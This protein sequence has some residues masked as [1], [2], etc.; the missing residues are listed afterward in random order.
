MD[1]DQTTTT[2]VHISGRGALSNP[3][4]R[5]NPARTSKVDDG[6]WQDEVATRLDTQVLNESVRTIISTNT[7][8]D[9]P[10]DQSI[11]PYRGCEHG[12]I[13]CY[14]RPTHAY[15]DMS[16][17]LDFETKIVAKRGAADL[18]RRAF[19]RPGYVVRPI[20]IGAN[21]DPYQPLEANLRITRDILEVLREYQH[22]F[23]LITKGAL[24]VR[25]LD[26]LADMAQQQL[27]S[28]AVSV[29]TLDRELKVKLEPRTASPTARLRA[30]EALS[31]AGVRVTMMIAPVIPAINDHELEDILAAGKQAGASA[32][33]FILLRLP[34]EVAPMFREWLAEH[35]P[36]RA[37]HVMS[38]VQQSRGGKDYASGFGTRMRGEGVF[39]KLIERRFMI[40]ARGLGL[41]PNER[42][43][44][45]T[46]LFIRHNDQLTLF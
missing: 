7:S 10:F 44:L 33:N 6:W 42:T 4:N 18:L 11:N 36:D 28:A 5:F 29:T 2:S 45:R 25:D 12:C 23:S 17:G 31:S 16:P 40:A 15:W 30:I 43:A 46:D 41:I 14:A 9:I 38:L 19:D 26:L 34:L 3:H 35:F 39:A 21:T 13:Y 24:V 22:P 1:T 37:R 32:A 27:C 8:P 20:T